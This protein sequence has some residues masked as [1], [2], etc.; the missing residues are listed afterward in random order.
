MK[1]AIAGYGLEGESSYRY[2]A[3]DPLNEL[4]IVDS[5]QPSRDLPFG[6][7]TIIDQDVFSTALSDFDLVVRTASLSPYKIVTNGKIWSATN[8]FFSKCP[9]RII[10]VT[11]TKGKGTIASLITR[12]LESAGKNVWLLGNIGV[13]ALDHLDKIKPDDFVV[14]ELSSFQL[15]DLKYSP[16]IAVVSLIEPEHLDIHV[17]FDDYVNAKANIRLRQV[18]GDVCIYHPTNEYSKRVA[19]VNDKGISLRYATPD[20][21]GVYYKDDAFYQFDHK[22]CS[23]DA[24]QLIG[25]H[26]I[27]NACAAITAAKS[28]A[29]ED[30]YIEDGLRHFPGLPHRLEFVREINGVKYYNDSFSS[31]TPATVAAIRAFT[32]P[33][34]LIMGGI[35]RG[36]NFVEIADAMTEQTN[37]KKVII[38]GEIRE[39]LHNIL[40]LR[41]PNISIELSDLKSMKDIVLLAKTYAESGDVIVLSPGCASFDMFKDFYDRGDQF[42]KIVNEL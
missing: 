24:L 29:I 5:K 17:D 25:R 18:D 11:G 40:A 2:Y 19:M 38:I 39:K 20:D 28:L 3:A 1:I 23:I 13:A 32:Q 35:D 33:E 42:R 36:G 37:I 14:Y 15:W 10:G 9:A 8:E 7:K 22:I 4:T 30:K 21:G 34:I 27:E 12:I 31:S 16:N 6:A 26:N 41:N